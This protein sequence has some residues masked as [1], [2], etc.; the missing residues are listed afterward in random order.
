MT[1]TERLID[2]SNNRFAREL[3]LSAD[4]DEAPNNTV[5]KV[6]FAL[7]LGS[8]AVVTTVASGAAAS[9]GFAA[10]LGTAS[11][12]AAAP[13]A[14]AVTAV[15]MLKVMAV[16][17]LTCGTL[18]YGGVKL[19]LKAS[20]QRS[21]VA[22]HVTAR[23]ASS[24]TL[25]QPPPATRAVASFA[26]EVAENAPVPPAPP[27]AD[28]VETARGHEQRPASAETALRETN[29]P[30]VGRPFNNPNNGPLAANAVNT[31]SGRT[32]AIPTSPL[33]AARSAT[34]P[35]A[36]FPGDDYPTAEKATAAL[37]A[38]S[39]A[40]K[41][42]PAVE[43]EREVAQLD[44]ARASLAAGQP[45]AAMQE[46][47]AYRTQYPRGVLGAESVVLR[48]RALLALGQ[49]SAAEREAHPLLLAAPYSRHAER[50]REIL[51]ASAN[52]Q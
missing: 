29:T 26:P 12:A 51:G 17:S 42:K 49:R 28:F 10:G 6:A 5:T 1:P 41:A 43:L 13:A 22:A 16:V 25:P 48:V 3:L 52:A 36:R 37:A 44:H 31:R 39:A 11:A 40:E 50:L 9:K 7:G 19:A 27:A 14:S 23:P 46:L 8:T 30:S 38:Q 47:D 35:T 45:A 32:A 24:P 21:A 20:A 34:P 2:S 4:M 18:S 33:S 15:G